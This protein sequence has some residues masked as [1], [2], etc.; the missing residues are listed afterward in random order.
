MSI[1]SEG[2]I[3]DSVIPEPKIEQITFETT[4]DRRMRVKIKFSISDVVD[5]ND[6]GTWFSEAEY[7]KYFLPS[8]ELK[9][10]NEP[11]TES[12][13]N[14]LGV[15][16]TFPIS[17]INEPQTSFTAQDGSRINKFSFEYKMVLDKEP[18]YLQVKI[19]SKFDIESLEREEGID[20][21]F[22]SESS[23][24]FKTK[25]AVLI[26]ESTV[27]YPIQDFRARNFSTTFSLDED[28]IL[29]SFSRSYQEAAE[30][31][32][33]DKR[34]SK[35]FLS[36]LMITRNAQGE[37]NFLFIFDALS[38][39]KRKSRYRS[40]FSRMTGFEQA[41][42]LRQT[43]IE[44]LKVKRKRVRVLEESTGARSVI[45]YSDQHTLETIAYLR[46]PSSSEEFLSY[47]TELGS[48]K[49]ISLSFEGS[50]RPR[51]R[52]LYFITGTDYDVADRTDGVYSYGVSVSI[53]DNLRGILRERISSFS[54]M[55]VEIEE[56]YNILTL[57][58]NYDS[59]TNL[60]KKTISAAL[61]TTVTW[62]AYTEKLGDMIRLFAP[63][64]QE[65][66]KVSS[67]FRLFKE[68]PE[69]LS[70]E[71][72][73]VLID[74]MRMVSSKA[75]S[76]IGESKGSSIGT[77]GIGS[78]DPLL[79]SEKF[80][81]YP[82]KLFDVNVPKMSGLE[83]LADFSENVSEDILLEISSLS[84][85]TGQVGLKVIDG[86]TFESR[87]ASEVTKFFNVSDSF[88]SPFLTNETVSLTSSGSSF[89]SPSAQHRPGESPIIMTSA[90]DTRS[91]KSFLS[92]NATSTGN[93]SNIGRLP[94]EPKF[95]LTGGSKEATF[96]SQLG[97]TFENSEE[98]RTVLKNELGKT[99]SGATSTSFDAI[100]RA[101]VN[102]V[103]Q[104][105][106]DFES[107]V[108][109]RLSEAISSPFLGTERTLG[110][111]VNNTVTELD[112]TRDNG[113]SQAERSDNYES[114]P[115][116]IK[117]LSIINSTQNRLSK[118]NKPSTSHGEYKVSTDFLVKMQYLTG[119]MRTT[120]GFLRLSLPTFKELT[121]DAY[122]ENKGKNLL[123][124][125]KPWA[126]EEMGIRTTKTG[127]PVYD[128]VFIIKPVED[129]TT[130]ES[131]NLP[132]FFAEEADRQ[133][134][135]RFTFEADYEPDLDLLRDN[136]TRATSSIDTLTSSNDD[137]LGEILERVGR[138]QTIEQSLENLSQRRRDP[139]R[140]DSSA[141]Q[142]EQNY[143]D[144]V[145]ETR[146]TEE[147]E[148]LTSAIRVL[149][150]RFEVNEE[151]IGRL[152]EE[153]RLNQSQLEAWGVT[154]D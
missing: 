28:T 146:L 94:G 131:I 154:S 153:V 18:Y 51:S 20:L 88:P 17:G 72:I 110:N 118:M 34:E 152:Q 90:T 139:F 112:V 134:H 49:Q 87:L 62:S 6:I 33:R 71:A 63:G 115:N 14:R 133:N 65:D 136:I 36:N 73:G 27:Q 98:A 29:N 135:Q 2:Q 42:V 109:S 89:L 80:Y 32:E 142:V 127:N 55:I 1:M 8:I 22:L 151:T 54:N 74:I 23:Q 114:L 102:Q 108:F 104:S 121:L 76:A 95:V 12:N 93:L 24:I 143:M 58:Q 97:V 144:S 78:T 117:S 82:T 101:S 81:T 116:Q 9:Y 61:E 138:K 41:S 126:M 38:F 3:L 16:Q 132:E 147:H 130:T 59:L 37:A 56:I 57:P 150:E 40:Y 11:I 26:D 106:K 119:F 141:T 15:S 25:T 10:N 21:S 77:R 68:T 48:A 86:A 137:I 67:F 52:G 105:R 13:P 5:D 148:I 145:L 111:T 113:E 31:M 96:L 45:D 103:N 47:D 128:S 66:D 44:S 79:V 124:R 83:Y 129:F 91:A 123:C 30:K 140:P 75:L 43:D 125:M 69:N 50:S 149:R 53:V 70:P 120:D 46:K 7:E 85:D 122:R 35:D 4:T 100:N 19:T 60:P 107:F 84:R 39:F 64:F 92:N 99:R